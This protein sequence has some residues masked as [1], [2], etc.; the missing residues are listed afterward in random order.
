M[1]PVDL[2]AGKLR[3]ENGYCFRSL[4]FLAINWQVTADGRVIEQGCLE[5]VAVPPGES[6][7]ITLLYTAPPAAPAREYHLHVKFCLAQDS[8]YAPRG[9]VMAWEQ[10]SLPFSAPEKKA[11]RETLPPLAVIEEEKGIKVQGEGFSVLIEREKG[12]LASF[13]VQGRE[14][15]S[16]SLIHI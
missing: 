6:R 4:D 1:H 7:E 13:A 10:F 5:P 3:V 15:I 11:S 9:H 2:K 8:P 16:L 12:C 14:L